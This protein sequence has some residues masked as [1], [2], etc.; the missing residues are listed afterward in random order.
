MTFW[1]KFFPVS[2]FRNAAESGRIPA[3]RNSIPVRSTISINWMMFTMIATTPPTMIRMTLPPNHTGSAAPA[4]VALSRA[5]SLSTSVWKSSPMAESMICTARASV[6]ATRTLR[7]V[8]PEAV[9]T[10]RVSRFFSRSRAGSA[11]WVQAIW[12]PAIITLSAA[13]ARVR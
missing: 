3:I 5:N 12:A 7:I 13:T 4:L 11:R 10:A 9:T 8:T 6:P 2:V 1:K